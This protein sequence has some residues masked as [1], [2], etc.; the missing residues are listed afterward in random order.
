MKE[1]FLLAFRA[2]VRGK[3]LLMLL[4]AVAL[5]HF[6]VPGIVRSDGSA[7]G[8]VEMTVRM[9]H[10]F[11]AAILLVSILAAACGMFAR[12]R[13]TKCL[14]LTMVRPVNA[15]AVAAGKWLALAAVSA[16][17]LAFSFAA[18][19]AFPPAGNPPS[20]RHHCRPSLPAP[21]ISAAKMLEEYLASPDTPEEIRKA[22]RSAVLTLLTAKEND[23][24][25]SVRKGETLSLPFESERLRAAV[26]AKEP[27]VLRLRF[28]TQFEMRTPVAGTIRFAGLSAAVSNVTQAVIEIPLEY[29]ASASAGEVAAPQ[30]CMSTFENTG[31]STV[32]LRPRCDIEM[33]VPADSFAANAIRASAE[34]WA[35][36]L[37]LAAFGLFLSSALSRP[38][39][40]FTAFVA[41]AAAMIA[42]SA[43]SQYPDE[44]HASAADRIGLAVSRAVQSVAGSVTEPAPVGDL[45]TGRAIEWDDLAGILAKDAFAMPAVL[46]LMA[47]FLARR[48]PIAE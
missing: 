21:E 16:L 47:A 14:A 44:F 20:C 25:E 24:Y 38:V 43:I 26:A 34:T 3:S 46:L 15:F 8:T 2:M 9:V 1:S 7:A 39:A 41:L 5:V 29:P 42:P 10:G 35:L 33:L 45:A 30:D 37:L 11:V 18:A 17:T 40:V 32:M 22:S 19:M 6:L 23:R 13:E 48:K 27:V 12:E 28:S 4:G 36:S 31:S